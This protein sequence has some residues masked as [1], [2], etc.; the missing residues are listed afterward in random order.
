[1]LGLGNATFHFRAGDFVR[2][3]VPNQRQHRCD[4]R[5]VLG[6]LVGEA[7]YWLKFAAGT[8]PPFDVIVKCNP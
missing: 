7:A 6:Q 5:R 1:V 2:I 3:N 8:E 4:T